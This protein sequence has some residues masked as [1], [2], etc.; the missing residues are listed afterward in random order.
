MAEVCGN[1]TPQEE[2]D[3]ISK[4]LPTLDGIVKLVALLY[5][6]IE[7]VK[8]KYLATL[9]EL[10]SQISD[11][12]I[13][14]GS[15]DNLILVRNNVVV[16]LN[17][18]FSKINRVSNAISGVDV[19]LRVILRLITIFGGVI[20]VATLIRLVPT[21]IPIPEPIS[22]RLAATTDLTQDII[23]KIQFSPKGEQRLVPLIGAVGSSVIAVGLLVNTLKNFICKLN[24]LDSRIKECGGDPNLLVP[25]SPEIIEFVEEAEQSDQQSVIETTYKG[26]IFEI[27]EVS[28]SPTVKRKRALA[29]NQSGITLLQTELSFTTTP[30]ILIQELKFVIDR[31]NLR[32]N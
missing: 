13:P 21:L 3:L 31:D 28:F 17:N 24:G 16:G 26:F 10:Y 23:K 4:L 8:I 22:R 27:E 29:K 9:D 30:D 5:S 6:K 15:L 2:N 19:F 20:T 18:L 1:I 11:A 25:V 14:P 7:E 12:C 32:A